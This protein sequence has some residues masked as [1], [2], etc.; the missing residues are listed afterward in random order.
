MGVKEIEPLIA[1]RDRLEKD[2]KSLESVEETLSDQLKSLS[3]TAAALKKEAGVLDAARKKMFSAVKQSVEKELA[4]LAMPGARFHAEWRPASRTLAPL[5]LETFPKLA[6]HWEKVRGVL[7]GVSERGMETPEFLL[8]SNPGEAILPLVR[9]ASGGELS[10]IM[11]ALKKALAADAE[12]C[13]LVFDEIDS[14]ISGRVADVVGKKMR[15]LSQNFQVI[16]ISHLPQVAVYSDA[17][18]LV[19]KG[20]KN[21]RTETNIVRLSEEES[22]EEIARLLSGAKVT[23]A[24][25]TNAKTLIATAHGRRKK[26]AV[27]PTARPR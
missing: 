17:H 13:V 15:E 6:Q 23:A 18:F 20:G 4:E 8:A 16:C 9:I 11:L 22:A 24:S 7:A 10:R 3:E 2:L 21:E 1:E 27:T 5:E 14:G 26:S 25:L 19:E 12:T